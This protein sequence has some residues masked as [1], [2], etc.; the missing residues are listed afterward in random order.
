[1]HTELL[2]AGGTYAKYYQLQHTREEQ[3]AGISPKT[4]LHQH[5]RSIL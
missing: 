4:G 3:P 5:H 1:V 2:Q